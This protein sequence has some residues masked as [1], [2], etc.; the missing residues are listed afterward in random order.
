MAAASATRGPTRPACQACPAQTHDL[1][2]RRVVFC[3]AV[4][5][6]SKSKYSSPRQE[7]RLLLTRDQSGRLKG[8]WQG[9]VGV[10]FFL[11]ARG[12]MLDARKALETEDVVL[13]RSRQSKT[14]AMHSAAVM[15]R[16]IPTKSRRE[17]G[18]APGL[19]PSQSGSFGHSTAISVRKLAIA[20]HRVVRVTVGG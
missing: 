10:D 11:E 20:D 12:W 17:R 14:Q 1:P 8:R 15:N 9:A 13:D 3:L 4:I 2:P 5:Q 18:K 7:G 16:S 6:L 19:A